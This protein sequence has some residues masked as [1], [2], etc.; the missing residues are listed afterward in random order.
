MVHRAILTDARAGSG[1]RPP[2]RGSGS[3]TGTDEA[4]VGADPGLVGGRRCRR[5][6]VP[7]AGGAVRC[8]QYQPVDFEWDHA[9]HGEP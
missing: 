4:Q 6:A 7:A 2:A 5:P 1:G 3:G 8:G 9:P